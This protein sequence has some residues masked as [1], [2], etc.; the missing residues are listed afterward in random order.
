VQLK[1]AGYA[2]VA[3]S[4][5]F[6]LGSLV[7]GVFLYNKS[8]EQQA[9]RERLGREGVVADAVVERLWRDGS[10]EHTPHVRYRFAVN[11][12]EFTG[13]SSSPNSTWKTLHEGDTL[14]VRYVP[15]D[16]K[17]NHPDQW[18]VD[19][20]PQWLAL[21]VPAMFSLGSAIML[22][23]IQRQWRLLSEG[24]AAQGVVTKMRRTDKGTSVSYE[25]RLRNGAVQKG[26][27]QASRRNAAAI[28][29]QVCILYDPDN[30]RR[31]AVYPMCLV[32]LENAP[33]T[34]RA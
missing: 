24:R 13:S 27:S 18:A 23:Q 21:V 31:N 7:L 4:V 20:T 8:L 32:Q 11:S 2:L 16:P 1:P 6:F 26:R 5:I 19:V 29:N 3:L 30:P 12:Q 15:A 17:V 33:S 25:F 14:P 22:I 28:G 9:T 10:K 34:R